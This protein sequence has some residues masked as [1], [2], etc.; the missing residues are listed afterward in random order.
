MPLLQPLP[1]KKINSTC[2]AFVFFSALAF[3]LIQPATAFCELPAEASLTVQPV[4]APSQ[5][6]HSFGHMKTFFND[7][8]KYF[9]T[10]YRW[11]GKTPAGFDCSGFVG[12]MYDKVFNMHLPRT[13]RE[14]SAIGTKVDKDQLQPGDLVFFQSRGRGINHVGIF[15]GENSFVHSSTSRGVVEEQLKQNFYEKQF[16]GAVRL[17]ELPVDKI[18]VTVP[19]SSDKAGTINPS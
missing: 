10:R 17:L 8:T 13:S 14:M 15:I 9:G 18:P 2:R 12:F 16:V 7:V 19:V 5:P 3:Q 4:E 6:R 1:L 11:G